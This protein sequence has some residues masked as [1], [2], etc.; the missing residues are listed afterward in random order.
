[1]SIPC[2]DHGC[3]RRQTRII[4]AL[5]QLRYHSRAG[6]LRWCEDVERRGVRPCKDRLCPLHRWRWRRDTR[7]RI[8][9]AIDRMSGPLTLGTVSAS[10]PSYQAARR[11]LEAACEK[12]RRHF[13]RRFFVVIQFARAE[14][15]RV[16]AHGHLVAEGEPA[17][18]G[19]QMVTAWKDSG[20]NEAAWYDAG[21]VR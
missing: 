9:A 1:V 20:A 19:P 21:R 17:L 6:R 8:K 4:R 7:K 13:L 11:R 3:T 5:D 10:G 12:F 2:Y 14:Y 16:L 15:G 18:V